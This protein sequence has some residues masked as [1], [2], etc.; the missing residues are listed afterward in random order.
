MN[1]DSGLLFYLLTSPFIWGLSLGLLFAAF[2]WRTGLIR[3]KA[4]R[5]E[6]K[7]VRVELEASRQH[8]DRQLKVNAKGLE[9]QEQELTALKQ[10]NL[11]LKEALATYKQK[12]NAQERRA[13]LVHDRAIRSMNEQAPGFA[14]AWE[15][16]CREAE[17]EV[18]ASDSGLSRI[19]KKLVGPASGAAHTPFLTTAPAS[20]ELEAKPGITQSNK[21]AEQ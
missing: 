3:R 7:A 16:A 2:T 14:P 12:P 6:L 11:N 21:A 18:D 8:L 17:A 10:E 9:A 13:L 5:D 1:D 19:V 20:D 15:Q 4:L